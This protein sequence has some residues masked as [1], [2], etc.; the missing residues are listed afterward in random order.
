M[1]KYL[2]IL[3]VSS[4]LLTGCTSIETV[5]VE[6]SEAIVNLIN[7][8]IQLRDDIKLKFG[9]AQQ[10]VESVNEA[11]GAIDQAKEDLSGL[12]DTEGKTEEVLPKTT[13]E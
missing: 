3:L 8:A 12:V 7:E 13:E 5:T 6:A 2:A 1:K 9:Q 10:A 11:V 4:M